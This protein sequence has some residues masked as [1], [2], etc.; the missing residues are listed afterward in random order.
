MKLFKNFSTLV[1]CLKHWH[2]GI[3]LIGALFFSCEQTGIDETYSYTSISVSVVYSDTTYLFTYNG[4]TVQYAG[5]YLPL[6]ISR[7]DLTGTLR[8]YRGE[9]LEL[10]TLVQLS[11]GEKLSFIQF[12]GEKIKFY[13]AG[14]NGGD[15]PDPTDPACTKARFFYKT[16]SLDVA[17]DSLRFIWLSSDKASLSL[18]GAK[19]A[20]FD[21]IVVHRGKLS[22]YV[23]FDTGEYAPANTYFYYTRQTWNGSAWTGTAKTATTLRTTL[24]GYK[25]AA[26]EYTSG[27]QFELIFG[28]KW[29]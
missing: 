2:I 4:D 26:Y 1:H 6:E 18:P 12:S 3:F 20:A 25:F 15:E 29:E 10:D 16:S 19:S 28:T 17:N 11:P 24:T 22:D 23:E 14:A 9:A 27:L 13:D 5:L 7:K 21:T 8:A